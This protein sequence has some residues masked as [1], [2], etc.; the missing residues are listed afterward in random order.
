MLT[1]DWSVKRTGKQSHDSMEFVIVS[2]RSAQLVQMPKR[3]AF[4]L[5]LPC[6]YKKLHCNRKTCGHSHG[7]LP[8]TEHDTKVQPVPT[9]PN[10]HPTTNL[11]L[12]MI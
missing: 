3:L 2:V 12:R 10:G 4:S 8:L 7:D 1:N 5:S 6:S 11:A 9:V